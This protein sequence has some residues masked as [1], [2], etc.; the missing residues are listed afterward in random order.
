M[1]KPNVRT[2]SGGLAMAALAMLCWACSH[3]AVPKGITYHYVISGK[4]AALPTPGQ[5]RQLQISAGPIKHWVRMSGKVGVM[6]AMTMPYQ[7]AAG[8][9]TAGLKVGERIVFHYKVNWQ[10]D[11]MEITS[12]KPAK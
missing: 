10:R 7:L 8:V 12:I 3:K 11:I 1:M 9:S 5:G 2:I 4:I 6:P